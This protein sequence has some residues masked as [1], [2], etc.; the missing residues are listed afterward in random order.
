MQT[1]RFRCKRVFRG[2]ATGQA[3]LEA[4][5]Q[6]VDPGRPP[7]AAEPGGPAQRLGEPVVA[8]AREHRGRVR[9]VLGPAAGVVVAVERHD[10]ERRVAVVVQAAHEPRVHL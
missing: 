9:A 10:F 1:Q 3:R 2:T 5:T 6:P 8:A 7:D 4:Q